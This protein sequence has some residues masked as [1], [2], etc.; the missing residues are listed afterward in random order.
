M[1]RLPRLLAVPLQALAVCL[2][3]ALIGLGVN[4]A[5]PGG[6]RLVAPFPYAQECPDKA[7]Q[8]PLGPSLEASTALSLLAAPGARLLDARPA[9]DY[10]ASHVAAARSLPY[11]FVSPP[12]EA[13]AAELRPLAHVLVY[14]D[15]PGDR[16]AGLLA[17]QLRGL[18]LRRVRVVKGGLDAL[19]QAASRRG[20]TR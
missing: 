5:R 2:G 7:A 6:L 13:E 16:L 11:S 18:G 3:L 14:C 1:S 19:R 12:G 17:D 10:A 8:V 9:E 20:G 15:S 4:A